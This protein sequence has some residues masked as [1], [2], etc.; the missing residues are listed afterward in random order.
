[1]GLNDD[2]IIRG[3]ILTGLASAPGG[4][5]DM[6]TTPGSVHRPRLEA[7][8]NDGL[9][10]IDRHG[11]VHITRAGWYD[12]GG[13]RQ[14][15]VWCRAVEAH[16]WREA[17]LDSAGLR[18]VIL[19]QAS[20]EQ[21]YRRLIAQHWPPAAA[22]Q[23]FDEATLLKARLAVACW[24]PVRRMDEEAVLLRAEERAQELEGVTPPPEVT[25]GAMVEALLIS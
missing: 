14:G 12:L 2:R 18:R 6:W 11:T 25:A 10:T 1:M 24:V 8:R 5:P 17:P 20:T 22:A 9:I 19:E 16:W 4:D 21:A 7:M 23:M 13:H 15:W 3:A